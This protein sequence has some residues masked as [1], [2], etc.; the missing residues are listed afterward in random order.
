MSR[1]LERKIREFVKSVDE[2]IT[3]RFDTTNYY[4]YE[5]D[6]VVY[7][8]DDINDNGFLRHIYEYHKSAE[9]LD[10]SL[11]MWSILHEIGHYCTWKDEYEN[12]EEILER[13]CYQH[14]PCETFEQSK[15]MQDLY[16]GMESEWNATEWAID[17][18]R[19]NYPIV[20]AYDIILGKE[21]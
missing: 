20:K 17:Y 14:F 11:L 4:D 18:A 3:V 12:E 10:L 15:A 13:Y 5:N 7:A 1:K 6:A 16:F 8:P 19:K 2:N 9:G 21:K